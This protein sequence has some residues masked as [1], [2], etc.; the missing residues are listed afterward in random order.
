MNYEVNPQDRIAEAQKFLDT[1]FGAVTG[2][3]YGYLWTKHDD[4]HRIYHF[5]V[6]ATFVRCA[7]QA[8][9]ATIQTASATARVVST[10]KIDSTATLATTAITAGIN[11]QRLIYSQSAAICKTQLLPIYAVRCA[12]NS[13]S[14][15]SKKA[16]THHLSS[17]ERKRL[18]R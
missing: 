17:V 11:F 13:I 7:A 8:K 12:T 10:A 1:L 4:D 15:L 9:A 2:T 5:A 14:L 6:T 16:T 3:R 18:S